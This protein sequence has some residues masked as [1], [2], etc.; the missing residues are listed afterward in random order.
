MSPDTRVLAV[1]LGATSIRVAAVNLER[2]F[3]EVDIV[4][5]FGHGPVPIGG[6]LRWDWSRILVEVK[7]GLDLGLDAGP[8]AS[9][10]IDGWGVDYG[11]VDGRGSLVAPPYSY[12]DSRTGEWAKTAEKIGYEHLYDVTG[13][14][15]MPFNTIFQLAAHPEEELRLAQRVLLLPDLLMRELGGGEAAEK[16]NASTTGL[17]NARTGEW[18]EDLVEAI[19]LEQNLFPAIAEAG[20]KVG[21]WEGVPLHLVGSH[22]TASAFMGTPAAADPGTVFVS[23]GTWVIVG[24]EREEADTSAEARARNFSNEAGA[25]GGVRFLKNVVGFW[26]IEQCRPAWGNASMTE[27]L[28]EAAAVR[29]KVPVFDAADGRFLNPSDME[30]EIR[31]AAGLVESAPRAV[32]VRSALESIVAG[33]ATVVDELAAITGRPME[34]IGLVGGGARAPL[35]KELLAAR[36]GLP[37]VVGSPEA[38]ALGNAVVQGIALG[39]FRNVLA[40]REWIGAAA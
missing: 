31:S 9:I 24:V 13:M 4:H 19:G 3:P 33:V 27:L 28:E 12:R 35:L 17:L 32:V 29:E 39:A 25:L 20:R 22:D 1:D 8:V 37:V 30:A 16:S 14:Q 36:T 23:T 18:A 11:L 26:L 5:R 38:T 34:R 7:R 6:S 2:P 40:A 21:L 10:G 15:L